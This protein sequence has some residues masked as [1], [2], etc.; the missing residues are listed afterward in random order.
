MTNAA[1]GQDIKS[2]QPQV[3]ELLDMG[4][5]TSIGV[6]LALRPDVAAGPAAKHTV[7]EPE[8]A[9]PIDIVELMHLNGRVAGKLLVHG[10]WN[11]SSHFNDMHR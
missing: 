6:D 4:E 8:Y 10:G 5:F 9:D 3:D 2:V 7:Q 1:S 11:H